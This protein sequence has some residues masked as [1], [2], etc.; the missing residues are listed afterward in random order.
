MK[1]KMARLRKCQFM[2]PQFHNGRCRVRRETIAEEDGQSRVELLECQTT[3]KRPV[4]FESL[5]AAGES[6]TVA[7]T[8]HEKG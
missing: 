7:G 4:V 1:E 3:D 8:F 6:K 2:D 5:H